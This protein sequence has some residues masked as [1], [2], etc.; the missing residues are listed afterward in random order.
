VNL[1]AVPAV[2]GEAYT[3][4]AGS[5]LVIGA[6][7]VLNNDMAGVAAGPLP[8][9]L[10]AAPLNGTVVLGSDGGFTYTPNKGFLGVDTFVYRAL[11]RYGQ[12]SAN[13]NVA[14]TVTGHRPDRASVSLS[15]AIR[16]RLSGPPLAG[17]VVVTP[18]GRDRLFRVIGR[19]DLKGPRSSR[20]SVEIEGALV[21]NGRRTRATG[22][23]IVRDASGNVVVTAPI[24][25]LAR[26]GKGG[27]TGTAKVRL[28]NRKTVT[29]TF[30]LR[31]GPS[32]R[33]S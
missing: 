18:F 20:Y 6:A 17:D 7:G 23:V 31:D 2:V 19:M 21:P 12:V 14:V 26:S 3:M 25:R 8:A 27:A 32:N 15:G 22:T 5:Q 29:I 16:L 9:A 13:A 4:A 33:R 10:I 11:D 24:T 30:S 28:P 1:P